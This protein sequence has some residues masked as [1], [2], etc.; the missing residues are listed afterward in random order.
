MNIELNNVVNWFKL[1]RL[2][3]NVKKTNF[4]IFCAKNKSYPRSEMSIIVDGATVDLVYQTKFLGVFIDSKLS[5]S[6]HINHV[7]GK[8]SKSIGIITKAR[9]FLDTKTLTGLYYTFI[10]PYLNYCCTVWGIAPESQLLKLHIL[11]KRIV[12]IIMGKPRL[13]PSDGLFKTLNILKIQNLNVFKL[14]MFCYKF[15]NSHLPA[16]FDEFITS[17]SNVHDH[18][19]RCSHLFYI[20]TPRTVYAQSSVEYNAPLTWNSLSFEIQ[21][22]Q[23]ETSFK[24]KLVSYLLS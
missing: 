9:K 16:I 7:A 6:S 1:N 19:T 8:I 11:Q 14:S 18:H 2:C 13:F 17:I 10:Y 4:M 5:W 12:R 24:R 21:T 23:C 3:L 15:K 20:K 22:E